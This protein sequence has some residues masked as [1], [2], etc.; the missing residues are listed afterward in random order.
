MKPPT[1]LLDRVLFN[2]Y[3]YKFSLVQDYDSLCQLGL[4]KEGKWY[5][6][7]ILDTGVALRF[8]IRAVSKI[9]NL[10]ELLDVS[11]IDFDV[12]A[13]LIVSQRSHILNPS[14]TLG[15]SLKGSNMSKE[16]YGTSWYVF[17]LG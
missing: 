12:P 3:K 4:A 2:Y 1:N 17:D 6:L 8:R 13:L 7:L 5:P 14:E 16:L 15:D 11:T 10:N 9:Y